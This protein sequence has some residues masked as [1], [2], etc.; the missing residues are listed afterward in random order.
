MKYQSLTPNI[1]VDNVAETV[2]FYTEMLGFKEVMN[3]SDGEKLVWAMVSCGKVNLMFQ[4]KKS[5]TEEYPILAS[6]EMNSVLSFYIKVIDMKALYDKVR[7]TSYL[8][9]DLNVTAYG[10]EEF[11]IIDNNGFILTITED[12]VVES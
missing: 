3:V 9:K 7:S 10:A 12:V 5:L 8:A 2:C 6:R 11:A 1:G 4:D